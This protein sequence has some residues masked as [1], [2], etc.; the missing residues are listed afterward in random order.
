MQVAPWKESAGRCRLHL[1][2]PGSHVPFS[3]GIPLK[4]AP[5]K[6]P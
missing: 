1:P 6:G 4:A 5:E 2:V 3:L